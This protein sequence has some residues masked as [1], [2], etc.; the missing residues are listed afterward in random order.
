M[1]ATDLPEVDVA[2]TRGRRITD[3]VSAT[4][5]RSAVDTRCVRE[6]S[7]VDVELLE[8]RFVDLYLGPT[9]LQFRLPLL[10]LPLRVTPTP[11]DHSRTPPPFPAV[12]ATASRAIHE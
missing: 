4:V 3:R 5:R 9:S 2:D 6:E 10:S 11:R 12:P 7:Y 1:R 8:F